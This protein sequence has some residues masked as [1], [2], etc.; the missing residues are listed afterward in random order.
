MGFL[1]FYYGMDYL[2]NNNFLGAICVGLIL[3]VIKEKVKFRSRD[4]KFVRILA[5]DSAVPKLVVNESSKKLWRNNLFSRINIFSDYPKNKSVIENLE[6]YYPD[7]LVKKAVSEVEGYKKN[8][9]ERILSCL[10]YRVLLK[11]IEELNE[12]QDIALILLTTLPVYDKKEKI[13]WI[14]SGSFEKVNCSKGIFGKISFWLNG[15][16]SNI[17]IIPYQK[18]VFSTEK[19]A[20]LEVIEHELAHL[21]G[22]RNYKFVC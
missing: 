7:I 8:S 20:I 16:K 13:C 6:E 17:V 14:N 11:R 21:L 10:D 12:N 4:I 2:V 19:E 1:S 15:L 9:S 3:F 18:H 22:I 5:M